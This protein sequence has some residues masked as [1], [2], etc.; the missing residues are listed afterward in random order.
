M[1]CADG[2]TTEGS[3]MQLEPSVSPAPVAVLT[4][5]NALNHEIHS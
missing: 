5:I 2:A 3:E 1:Q 4:L